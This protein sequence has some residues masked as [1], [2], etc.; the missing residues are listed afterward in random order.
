[1]NLFNYVKI[2][3][4][5]HLNFFYIA[6]YCIIYYSPKLYCIIK[7]SKSWWPLKSKLKQSFFQLLGRAA[8]H[9]ARPMA[10]PMNIMI[11]KLL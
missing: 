9:P 5:C 10:P 7:N 1:M 6:F 8:K 11:T 3:I 2:I 4:F